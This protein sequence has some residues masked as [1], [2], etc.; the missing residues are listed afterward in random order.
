MEYTTIVAVTAS[1]SVPLQFLAPY[2]GVL[3]VNLEIME[4]MH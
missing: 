4:C 1:D 2:T 3:W